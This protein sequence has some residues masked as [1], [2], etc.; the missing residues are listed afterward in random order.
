MIISLP[1][2]KGYLAD[3]VQTVWNFEFS[4]GYIDKSHV[5]VYHESPTGT[6]VDIPI[7]AA[8]FIGDYQLMITPAVPAGNTIVI[9]RSTPK[10]VPLVD[11][12]DGAEY[13]EQSFDIIAKQGVFIAAESADSRT[14]LPVGTLTHPL[15]ANSVGYS[16]ALAGSYAE[17]TVGH[18]LSTHEA[19]L[20]VIAAATGAANVGITPVGGVASSTVQ[21]AVAELD[22]EWRAGVSDANAL[23]A[24]LT[25]RVDAL[26]A[27]PIG[28]GI[29]AKATLSL[30]NA[31]LAH[32]DATLGF[33]TN[34]AD[35]SK[36]GWYRK[37]GA[38]GAGSWI[39]AA[40]A[41][42][43]TVSSAAG[44]LA[45]RLHQAVPVY[46]DDM[47]AIKIADDR[48]LIRVPVVAGEPHDYTEFEMFQW[49]TYM[50]ITHAWALHSVR[51][52]IGG[53]TVSFMEQHP[54]AGNV[55]T[56]EFAFKIGK[57]ADYMADPMRWNNPAYFELYGFGHGNMSYLGF[58]LYLD[59]GV[60]NYR[61]APVGTELR[62][63]TIAFSQSFGPKTP[64]GTV[65]G[66]HAVSH[67]FTAAGLQV[68]HQANITT[69]GIV[70]QNS[71][72][73]MAAFTGVNAIKAVASAPTVV[74][75]QDGSQVGNWGAKDTFA[76]YY[77]D[78][79][80]HL[81][82]MI[83][84]YTGPVG[85]IGDWSQATTSRTFVLDNPNRIRKLYVNWRSGNVST[86]DTSVPPPSFSGIY[87][88]L[89]L[90][91]VR[92]GATI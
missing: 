28:S 44:Q 18:Y 78:R 25:T 20:G 82:E 92:K 80:T 49:G 30:L 59:G 54:S 19:K 67:N 88:F 70:C 1:T 77:S 72:S 43:N 39:Q 48:W 38:S 58:G 51:A 83:L 36:N 65:V 87:S 32:N 79:S 56:N 52:R 55:S 57:L 16:P 31:D 50:G 7:T 3:G 9:Y 34:D 62:G 10:N 68:S 15:G 64:D 47:I 81:C 21:A 24:G 11:F 29:V 42:S 63:T 74:G 69:P 35:G 12:A 2:I 13:S 76:A 22:S 61:D 73:A 41:S 17:S 91:R 53:V 26:E 27:T 6:L 23:V 5:K 84:P 37:S 46:G 45:Y 33:V 85:P 89:T 66:T 75:A 40:V 14:A 86:A 8:N 71:Y 90:Y 60:T 4:G